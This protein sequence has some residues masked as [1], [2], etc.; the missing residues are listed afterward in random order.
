MARWLSVRRTQ[1]NLFDH[2]LAIRGFTAKDLED[3]Y[4]E[5]HNP[6][7]LPDIDRAV[8]LIIEAKTQG[9]SAA[10]FGD[11]DADGTP[12]AAVL[13]ILLDQLK[14]PH[15][16]FIP[17]REKGYG[18]KKEAIDALDPNTKLLITVDNG[19]K[20]VEEIKYA[21]EKG[22]KVLV[23]DHHLPGDEL[24]EADALV[25]TFVKKSKYP[26]NGLCGC[27]LAYKLTVALEEKVPELNKNLSKWFLDLVAISTVADMMPPVDENRQLV[28]FGL[29]V[30]G[31]SRWPGVKALLAAA[32]VEPK[33]LNETTLGFVLGPRLNATGRMGDNQP[34]LDLLLSKDA[35][36]AAKLAW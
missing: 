10:I 15:Q 32:K 27:A 34:A 17:T 35:S 28:K 16:V 21:H 1:E 31:K 13:S 18:L 6:N 22:M 30:L 20:A 24:P 3:N 9:Y 19:I 33:N 23:L 8:D 4:G 25:D 11:Y 36:S 29:K 14:I 12:G 5:I 2:L 7:T 26:F